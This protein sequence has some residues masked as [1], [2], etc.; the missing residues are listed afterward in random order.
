M[1]RAIGLTILGALAVLPSVSKAQTICPASVG[2]CANNGGYGGSVLSIRITNSTGTL[3]NN[4]NT[5]CA[6]F[7]GSTTNVTLNPAPSA[8][9]NLQ[10]GSR[11]TIELTGSIWLATNVEATKV[12]IWI[13]MNRDG[14]LT[15]S[16]CIA[17]PN[18]G[19]F[20]YI[21]GTVVSASFTL[22]AWANCG[23]SVMRFRGVNSE[24]IYGQ[25]NENQGCGPITGAFGSYGNIRDLRV[26]L[27][28]PVTPTSAQV[29]FIVPP[30]PNFERTK[31]LFNASNPDNSSFNYTWKFSGPDV[32][33][34]VTAGSQGAASWAPPTPPATFEVKMIISTC[35]FSDS[36][37]K[38]ITIV[39]PNAVPNADFIAKSNQV[40]QYFALDLIDLSNNGAYKWSWEAISPNG[41][42]RTSTQQNPSI[43]LDSV[44]FW[45]I[46][47]T[48]E[49]AVGPSAK[50]CKT[51]YVECV[52]PSEYF[53]GITTLGEAKKGTLYDNGGRTGNYANG[54]TPPIHYFKLLP[55]GAKE[56]RLNFS[57]I[58]LADANDII[59]IYDASFENPA[60]QLTPAAGINSTNQATFRTTQF[61]ATSGAM[62]ITFQSNTSGTDSGFIATWDSDL[63]PPLKPDAAWTTPYNP[64]A[65]GTPV[66]FTNTSTKVQGA[67]TWEWYV[68]NN[69]EAPSQDFSK[70]FTADGSYSVC[71]IARTC[72]GS[73][74]FCNTLNVVTPTAPGILDYTASNIRPNKGDVVDFT[75]N[76]DYATN[77]EWNI[78]PTT[79]TIVS[80]SL[81]GTGRTLSLRFNQG[82]CYTFSLTGWNSAENP[83][84]AT[85]KQVIKNKFVCVIDYCVP[86]ANLL[87]SDIG[88]SNVKLSQGATTLIDYN[89]TSGAVSYSD[90]SALASATLTFGGTYKLDVA[91]PT[92]SNDVN[93]KAWI[94]F[95]VDGDFE[96]AGEEILNSGVINTLTTNG[97]FTVPSI[98]SSFEGKT[99]M[100][101]ASSFGNFS[102]T[103][104]G[105]N[106]VGEFEDYGIILANDNAA[107]VITLVGKDTVF[108]ERTGT[109]NGC[110]AE[111]AGTSYSASDATEGNM[112]SKVTLTSDLDC[113]IPGIYSIEFNVTDA[114]G[115]KAQTKRRTVYV[116]LDRTAPTLTL[117]G[118]ATETVE[119][120]GTYTEAGAVATDAVDG[121]LTSAIIISGSV[122][123]AKVGDYTLTYS[124]SDAQG[125]TT[126]KTRVVQVRDTKKPGIFTVGNRIVNNSI[127]KVQINSV[128]VDNIYA[129]DDCNGPIQV[130]KTNGFNGP[131]NTAI[132]ATYPVI[133]TAVDPNGNTADENGYVI[134]YQVDDYIAPVVNLNT[135]DV[136]THDVNTPYVSRDVTVSDNFYPLNKVSVVKTGSVDPYT[137]GT[138]TESY[139]ATD[140][141]GNSTTV[142]RTVN[143]VDRVAPQILAPAVN[144]CVGTPF[145]AMSGLIISDNY[146]SA[147]TLS[148]LVSVL[149]HNVNI[150]EAGLYYINYTLTDPSGNKA[151][152]VT[153]TVSVAYPP[154]CQNTFL[155]TTNISLD[156]AVNVF[157]NPSS[158]KVTL[159]YMLQNNK[160][161]SVEVFNISA[162][163]VAS[164]NNL[165]SGL[166]HTEI[167][168]GQFGNGVY[169]IRLSND[170]QTTTKRVV[171]RN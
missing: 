52:P 78:F 117:N 166:G 7:G 147:G 77:F 42:L 21:R 85:R 17:N 115:N 92:N 20:A 150:W 47:L 156:E 154:N 153:R 75:I 64:A 95:N 93:Y 113:T 10:A 167:N 82:G 124:V 37:S 126:T 53:I 86:L 99:R 73:D 24:A 152:M 2:S 98:T 50:K 55:C 97:T 146:Y 89:S 149:S 114:S 61:K 68:D 26:N 140:E 13:D 155:S 48:S 81:T 70:V 128:F 134:N 116:V 165:K 28:N 171:V 19:P 158:G 169:M 159:S 137:L 84:G 101:V 79:Y 141:S 22:P 39:R 151:V 132:R 66:K 142:T 170:G 49:N 44:G 106:T 36:I 143:V 41:G 96:D 91:R 94:D 111:A 34:I 164:F 133:Y 87:S 130:T 157:P 40:E 69:F 148:P 109:A 76:T 57:Q 163:K 35:T 6:S 90:F 74:T 110:W 38:N 31:I 25:M 33:N 30:S 29:N 100:R 123:T 131:V 88:I 120:C 135:A 108:V 58:K 18:T 8:A 118:N 103:P 161:V 15:A 65:I 32:T 129:Q 168:L 56:I 12:G 5:S 105:V 72:S 71:L 121:N 112:T 102:N 43:L 63:L 160:P 145:W 122:N 107:P 80:G 62:Y 9:V 67:A 125:N 14:N 16:E 3:Y 138:Y 54:C 46:C 119:Q 144:V 4:A 139:T 11:I 23:L 83:T 27:F 45:N 104:C 127:L 59:R 162:S 60:K 136:I 51:R 1:A